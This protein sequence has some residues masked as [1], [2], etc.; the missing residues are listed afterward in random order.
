MSFVPWD[1]DDEV[2]A[3]QVLTQLRCYAPGLLKPFISCPSAESFLLVTVQEFCYN[4]KASPKLFSEI[5]VFF[6]KSEYIRQYLK[7]IVWRISI[8]VLLCS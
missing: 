6:S 7:Q 3:E 4:N 8:F 2:V 1:N 5:I